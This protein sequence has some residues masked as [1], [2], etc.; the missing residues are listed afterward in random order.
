MSELWTIEQLPDRVADLLSDNYDGQRNGRIRELPNRR[1]IRW[2]TTIGLVDRPAATRGRTVLYGRRHLLQIVAVKKLQSSGSSLAEIQ[3]L[4]V[5]AT[6]TRLAELAGV[7]H[8]DA[9]HPQIE[10]GTTPQFWKGQA[11]GRPTVPPAA[12]RTSPDTDTDV[13]A[14]AVTVTKLIHGI[15]LTDSVTVV[16]EAAAHT[17]DADEI[18][19]IE[20]AAAP[21]LELL[22]RLGLAPSTGGETQ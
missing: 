4:L 16:L 6:D 14:G 5:G 21:L 15:R 11:H 3:E 8:I 2:Y 22:G 20:A 9:V 10:I 12:A 7:A 18:A 17:P 13:D 1:T 19:A